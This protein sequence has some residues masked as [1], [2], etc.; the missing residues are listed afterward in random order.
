VG[1][2]S[3]FDVVLGEELPAD[4]LVDARA[5]ALHDGMLATPEDLS[6]EVGHVLVLRLESVKSSV[7]VSQ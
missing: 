3:R 2:G 1:E 5:T 4:A 6:G 7:A